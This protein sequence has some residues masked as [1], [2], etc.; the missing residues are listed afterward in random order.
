MGYAYNLLKA[1]LKLDFGNNSY[2]TILKKY[3]AIVKTTYKSHPVGCERKEF[4]C[5]KPNRSK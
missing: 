5:P 1:I 4:F 3:F 2:A